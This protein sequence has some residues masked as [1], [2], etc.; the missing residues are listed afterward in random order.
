[1][2]LNSD[3]QG[4]LASEVGGGQN[5]L[6]R[7]ARAD[8]ARDSKRRNGSR[9]EGAVGIPK[10]NNDLIDVGGKRSIQNAILIKIG[11]DKVLK[12]DAAASKGCLDRG[13]ESAIAF[14]N[15]RIDQVRRV[16]EAGGIE[17]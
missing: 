17:V 9:P 4:P 16:V 7:G 3:R 1:M 13:V 6:G 14:P 12:R 10:E 8:R 15:Q 11:E 2:L 5:A